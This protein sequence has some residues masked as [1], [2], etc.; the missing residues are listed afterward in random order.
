[1]DSWRW[2]PEAVE[3]LSLWRDNEDTWYEIDDKPLK[4]Y[5]G[6][7]RS[8]LALDPAKITRLNSAE[9]LLQKRRP[10]D[11]IQTPFGFFKI[12][13]RATLLV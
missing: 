3:P 1:M 8:A 5:V 12:G 7:G 4:T 11:R 2:D 6:C 13:P 9:L 10:R